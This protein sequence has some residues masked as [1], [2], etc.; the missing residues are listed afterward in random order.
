[1]KDVT[2]K[3]L[4]MFFSTLIVVVSFLSVFA[5]LSIE[6]SSS[7]LNTSRVYNTVPYKDKTGERAVSSELAM[8]Y[9]NNVIDSYVGTVT[10]YGPDC[11]GCI[12]ITASGYKVAEKVD[13][14]FNTI[15]TTYNDKEYG[16]LRILAAD[17][18][19]FP[20]GT[21]L[22]ISGS[23]IEGYITGIVLDT[24]GAMRNAWGQGNILI[25]LMFS[26]EYDGECNKFGRKR[27]V[28]FEV[29]RYGFN[30]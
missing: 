13:G 17:N 18:S 26:T 27:N 1:M 16:E 22:R 5:S 19:K 15:T 30:S 21:V 12:G 8:V 28:T 24:G 7:I 20:F 14:V 23:N 3:L 2:S 11:V 29:L 25:D 9:D 4:K 6:K 10:A